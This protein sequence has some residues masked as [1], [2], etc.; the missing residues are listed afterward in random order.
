MYKYLTS[1]GCICGKGL[2]MDV[3]ITDV[4]EMGES[5]YC[6]AGW[7]ID[8]KRMVR[9]L[10]DGSNWP[11]ALLEQHSIVA[12]KLIR[13]ERKLAPNGIFPHRTEDMPI[14]QASIKASNGVFSDWLGA[15]APIVAQ[16]LEAG[17]ADQLKWNKVWNEVRQGVHTLPRAKCASL[18]SVQV[19]KANLVFSQPFESLKATLNDGSASY[20]LTVSSKVLKEAWRAGGLASVNDALPQRGVLHVRVGLARPFGDPLKCY[21]MLNGAL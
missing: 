12:G 3:L 1:N 17:F 9:P 4:T 15:S 6:V 11:S 8:E 10:P 19:P 13:V 5:T 20:Q 21:A 7:A 14:D 16:N 18:T 2:E